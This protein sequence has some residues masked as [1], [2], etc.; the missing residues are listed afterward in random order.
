M[1]EWAVVQPR[2]NPLWLDKYVDIATCASRLATLQQAG[3]VPDIAQE[4][5]SQFVKEFEMLKAGK[6]LMGS[7]LSMI[8][9]STHG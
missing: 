2:L 6:I 5:V 9:G 4:A 8:D 7:T 3:R 1:G